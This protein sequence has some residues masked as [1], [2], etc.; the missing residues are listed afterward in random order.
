MVKRKT[1]ASA[2]IATAVLSVLLISGCAQKE[3]AATKEKAV[4]PKTE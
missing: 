3:G 4:T 2:G 1:L